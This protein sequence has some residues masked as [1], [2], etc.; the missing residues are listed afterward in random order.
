MVRTKC[1]NASRIS[2][3]IKRSIARS[4]QPFS[5]GRA[6][7]SRAQCQPPDTVTWETQ[8]TP[9]L[10]HVCALEHSHDAETFGKLRAFSFRGNERRCRTQTHVHRML[11]TRPWP[12]IRAQLANRRECSR[13]VHRLFI[14]ALCVF[15]GIG[16]TQRMRCRRRCWPPTNICTNSGDSRRCPLG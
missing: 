3:E 15:W 14:V 9:F 10:P 8:L 13:S 6:R 5:Y 7:R 11:N 4:P 1:A 12:T 16:L 2:S